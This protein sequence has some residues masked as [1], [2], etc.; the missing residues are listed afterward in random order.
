M[1]SPYDLQLLTKQIADIAA[2]DT[3]QTKQ[4]PLKHSISGN[5]MCERVIKGGHSQLR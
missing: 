4:S 2:E 5:H 1:P 3:S